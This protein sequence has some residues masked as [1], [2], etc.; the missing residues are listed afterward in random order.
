MPLV[1]IHQS[2]LMIANHPGRALPPPSKGSSS[3]AHFPTAGRE[4]RDVRGWIHRQFSR[5]TVT[6]PVEASI[7]G[8]PTVARSP[9]LA[10][11]APSQMVG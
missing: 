2:I 1:T 4:C 6:R 5:F 9:W 7:P 3:P 10:R 8:Y 11:C